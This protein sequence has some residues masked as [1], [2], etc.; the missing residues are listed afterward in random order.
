MSGANSVN[1]S[2]VDVTGFQIV[3]DYTLQ[4]DFDDR[5]KRLINF[6]PILFGPLFG[7][8]CDL[9]LFNQVKLNQDIGTLTWPTG[10]DIDPIVLH[11]WPEHVDAIVE[12][13]KRQASAA[14]I[15]G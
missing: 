12:R 8:L 7:P 15:S 13:R 2:L 14:A 6:Q 5:T 9:D 3:D 4:I 11:D 10:A 1:A